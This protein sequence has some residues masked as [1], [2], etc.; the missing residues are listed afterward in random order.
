MATSALGDHVLISA[1]TLRSSDHRARKGGRYT[2]H[3]TVSD[4][5]S[6]PVVATTANCV[7]M[8]AGSS[9]IDSRLPPDL[10]RLRNVNYDGGVA[11]MLIPDD[12]GV[13]HLAIFNDVPPPEPANVASIRLNLYT[14]YVPIY[15]P[16]TYQFVHQVLPIYTPSTYQFVH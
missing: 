9:P 2:C 8:S 10:I 4:E 16:S 6:H 13:L 5:Q 11:W 12:E 3:S 7:S 14:K 15:T 1:V